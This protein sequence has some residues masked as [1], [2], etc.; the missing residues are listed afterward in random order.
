MAQPINQ[1]SNFRNKVNQ[2][3]SALE[4]AQGAAQTIDYL[5]SANFYRSELERVND[6]GVAIHDITPA[7]F[8][9]AINALASIKALL[10]ADNQ[11]I[12]KALARM[13]D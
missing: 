1:I 10:E 4:D 5:G 2:V 7:Q 9:G 11:A 12:G 13:R 3:L 8:T 6:V